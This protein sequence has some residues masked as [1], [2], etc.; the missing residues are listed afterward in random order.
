VT[1]AVN[2]F[3]GFGTTDVY[4]NQIPVEMSSIPRL[5]DSSPI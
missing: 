4:Y 2:R 3:S 1:V 5:R